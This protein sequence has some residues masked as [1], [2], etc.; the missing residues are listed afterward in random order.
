MILLDLQLLR[1]VEDT[2]SFTIHDTEILHDTGRT[3][4]IQLE[5]NAGEYVCKRIILDEVRLQFILAVENH[6]RA[7]GIRIPTILPTRDNKSYFTWD[8]QYYLLQEY[9]PEEPGL[10]TDKGKTDLRD[11]LDRA[12]LLGD[13][14]TASYGFST[15]MSGLYNGVLKWDDQYESWVRYLKKWME[16]N[17]KSS[18]EQKQIICEYLPYF[19]GVGKLVQKVLNASSYYQS[20]KYRPL[21]EQWVCHGDYHRGNVWKRNSQ[22]WVIDWEFT[23]HDFPSRDVE[24]LVNLMVKKLNTWNNKAFDQLIHSYLNHNPLKGEERWLLY[25]DL[26]FPH[27]VRR[28]LKHNLYRKMSA[29]QIEK[30]LEREYERSEQLLHM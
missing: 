20:W 21:S 9:I 17:S 4:V 12:A 11:L 29:S 13:I 19:Q 25:Q 8:G 28:L 23:R 27:G 22:Y 30:L 6:L 16:Q 5:T 14:H 3:I 1:E 2:Y 18:S 26:T 7:K 24:R 10:D 15:P